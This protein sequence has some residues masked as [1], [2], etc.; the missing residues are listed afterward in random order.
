MPDL[1]YNVKFEIDTSSTSEVG[2]MVNNLSGI[3]GSGAGSSLDNLNDSI[4][5]TRKS[6]SNLSK[7][8][9]NAAKQNE[10]FRTSTDKLKKSI[11]LKRTA[12]QSDL[13]VIVQTNA[14]AKKRIQ[15]LRKQ[16]SELIN[17]AN[18]TELNT[19]ENIK[20][21]REVGALE[22]QERQLI[23]QL[24]K[25]R[26]AL[27]GQEVQ[28]ESLVK[29][30][31]RLSQA[32][33]RL[34]QQTGAN[35]KAFSTANQ[36]LFSFSD[37]VQDSSQFMVGGSF[38]F[39]T[40][41]RA[42]GNNIG[43]TSEL[44]GNLTNRTGGLMNAFKAMGRSFLGPAGLV[45]GINAAITAITILSDKF[46]KNRKDVENA[47]D[48]IDAFSNAISNVT[49]REIIDFAESTDD[50]NKKIS[51]LRDAVFNVNKELGFDFQK[52]VKGFQAYSAKADK[53][54]V[55]QQQF[56]DAFNVAIKNST[57]NIDVQS[58]QQQEILSGAADIL[59]ER[60]AQLEAERLI[61]EA[62]EE[63]SK[64][65]RE[66]AGVVED[67]EL[68]AK[69]EQQKQ[70]NQF[71]IESSEKELEIIKTSDNFRKIQLQADLERFNTR[72]A[73]S[74]EINRINESDFTDEQKRILVSNAT[75]Q[76]RLELQKIN[77]QEEIN[78][79]NAVVDAK[80]KAEDEKT[81]ATLAAEAAQKAAREQARKDISKTL[82]LAGQFASSFKALKT[83]EIN[84]ELESAK[85]RGATAAEIDKINRKKF[86]A[87]KRAQI[88][89]SIIN[90]ASAVVEALPNQ[91]LAIATAALGAIQIATIRK[92]KYGGSG[93]V[94]A[95]QV[96]E[97]L[98]SGFIERAGEENLP[99]SGSLVGAS[100]NTSNFLPKA[101]QFQ[102]QQMEVVVV[103]TFNES[104]VAEV[105]R[106]GG[107]RLRSTQVSA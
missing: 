107:T 76:A 60:L 1:I 51:I 32:K 28:T 74:Q 20:L 64:K 34:H 61:A 101:S 12:S 67:P 104:T 99:I 37:L 54:A 65:T 58:I 97:S 3:S 39:A 95:N 8:V 55:S 87:E 9:R 53:A 70:L 10:L 14:Q 6:T 13:R 85:A 62:L 92:T 86:E 43:F 30:T 73:L 35:N 40:G 106:I 105:S 22:L 26:A 56:S 2:R 91:G 72:A 93:S 100:Q 4:N 16:K 50:I 29:D 47:K 19:D 57:K 59:K 96:S 42:I 18:A 71:N 79:E 89:S 80:K 48:Q 98:P 23:S 78:F 5:N 77:A 84:A 82:Q 103:N 83:Q 49:N 46:K 45:L 27:K 38:N 44:M 63:V 33:K 7:E 94:S 75:D 24:Q 31:D 69:F 102:Q 52:E 81:K 25:G 36:T 41:M 66:T 68:K 11:D 21:N 15:E 90:T 88:A 17:F